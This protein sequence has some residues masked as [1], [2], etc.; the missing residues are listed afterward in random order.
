VSERLPGDTIESPLSAVLEFRARAPCSGR[1][2]PHD[3][4]SEG[5]PSRIHAAGRGGRNSAATI[6]T[7]PKPSPPWGGTFWSSGNGPSPSLLREG[8]AIW[9][10]K[11][12][13]DWHRFDS[14]SLLGDSLLGRKNHAEAEPLLL[15]GYGGLKAPE[16]TIP[17]PE[18]V[19]L[20]QAGERVVR[21]YESWGKPEK[22]L[23]WRARL[24]PPSA[25]AKP[26]R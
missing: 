1:L 13:D 16:A 20:N 5:A 18:K 12:P 9:E 14:Q 8:T 21:L 23:E 25:E 11:R 26:S 6:A 19:R 15:S 2:S 10:A 4:S 7:S 17:A 24:T 22:A 3:R